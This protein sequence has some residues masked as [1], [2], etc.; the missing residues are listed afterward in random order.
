LVVKLYGFRTCSTGFV[1]P[2]SGWVLRNITYIL[3]EDKKLVMK[4]QSNFSIF[5]FSYVRNSLS[6]VCMRNLCVYALIS[7][8]Y[9]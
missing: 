2:L 6:Y 5:V 3:A 1:V 7:N 9:L 4:G 8:Y